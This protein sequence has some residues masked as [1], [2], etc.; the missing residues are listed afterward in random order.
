MNSGPE[1]SSATFPERV[2]RYELLI[3]IGTGGMATVYLG[4]VHV[5]GDV[6]REVALKLMHPFIHAEGRESAVSLIEE[7][8]LAVRIRH[9]NVI[10][11]VE[12]GEGPQGVFL[13]MEYVEGDTL[14]AINRVMRNEN[15]TVPMPIAARIITDALAGLHAAHELKDDLGQPFH[16]VHRDFSPQNILVGIDGISRLTD[17]GIAKAAGRMGV[18]SSGVIKGKVSYM[19]P[20]QA[21]G[22]RVDRRCDI[23]AAGIVV[24]ELLVGRRLYKQDDQVATLL[25]IVSETPPRVREHRPDIPQALDDL[26]AEAL[27][28]DV[29][30]RIP[31]AAEFR[32]RLT[33]AWKLAGGIAEASEVGEF[34]AQVGATKLSARR[35]QVTRVL[36]LRA[37]IALV[38][39]N[40]RASL[41]QDSSPHGS[42]NDETTSAIS[43][44]SMSQPSEIAGIHAAAVVAPPRRSNRRW[45]VAAVLGGGM[46]LGTA[47]ILI[48][49][50]SGTRADAGDAKA[51]ALLPTSEQKVEPASPAPKAP[52]KPASPRKVTLTSTERLESLSIGGKLQKIE[53]GSKRVELELPAD[54]NGKAL[55]VEGTTA[56]GRKVTRELS[57]TDSQ[58]ELDFPASRAVR[59]PVGSPR[60]P[61]KEVRD[62]VR[63]DQPGLAPT[64]YDK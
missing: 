5:V 40:A 57:A 22:K 15:R 1:E 9:P 26:V 11:V 53:A 20:E 63:S 30:K 54:T 10:P 33:E 48:W 21:L 51:A 46:T 59:G 36:R 19:A 60:P 8:K 44:S 47:A 6:Y 45:G 61:K 39:E 7:A 56:D 14:S 43:A 27:S 3:P 25:K 49:A 13:V 37:R 52:A 24:W 2:G 62:S 18:T 23:W 32:R 28:V 31:S 64:P 50:L 42:P 41:A 34:A 29:D 55:S 35:E 12:V 38:G 58:L 4:R 16:L 17:F